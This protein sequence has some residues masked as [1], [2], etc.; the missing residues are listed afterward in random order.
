[1]K[2]I[3]LILLL[4]FFPTN[5]FSLNISARS[6]ILMDT[7]SNRVLFQ[8]NINDKKLIASITK[9]MTCII[10][11]EKGNLDKEIVVGEEVLKMYGS[12]IYLE[13]G[14]KI[15]LKDLLYGLMLRSGNDAAIVVAINV[16]KTEEN[17]VKMMNSKAKELGM[18]DTIFS[19]PHGLDD[20]TKNYSTAYDMALLSSY[21][22]KN[23]IYMEITGT[24]KYKLATANKSYLWN[25]RN[26]LLKKYKYAISGK[27]GYTPSA[28]RTL[29]TV[30]K[31]D[32]L[33]LTAITLND[34][35]EY[36]THETLYEYGF[37]NYNNY[38]ILDKSKFKID[39]G[40]LKN[41]VYIKNNFSYPL[42]DSEKD[43]IKVLLK[44]EKT[45]N[46]L[47]N[48]RVGIVIVK[49]NNKEIHSQNIY[50]KTIKKKTNIF[51]Y[52]KSLFK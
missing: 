28:G 17:F 1:M 3:I 35:N 46:I 33:A 20:T 4:F 2:K 45:K 34:G 43:N 47:N 51:S 5:V 16:G 21:V 37:D 29:V 41:Q 6:A 40:F 7:D 14:E 26:L 31:K 38:I 15:K 30:A 10:A 32:N 24:K 48:D 22:S 27:N 11:I 49:L 42:T 12:N 18:N 50:A 36:I 23:D 39:D 9:I 25:N 52:I 13:L 44:I 19:N 8:K